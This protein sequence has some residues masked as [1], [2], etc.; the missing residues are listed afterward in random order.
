MLLADG[1][2]SVLHSL[3]LC[4]AFWY[5]L[6]ADSNGCCVCLCGGLLELVLDVVVVCLCLL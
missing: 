5:V 6:F 2:D 3:M 1:V 4:M